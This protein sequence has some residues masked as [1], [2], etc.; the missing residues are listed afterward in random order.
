MNV[1][2]EIGAQA[3]VVSDAL[4]D[5]TRVVGNLRLAALLAAVGAPEARPD[6]NAVTPDHLLC[7]TSTDLAHLAVPAKQAAHGWDGLREDVADGFV[8][9]DDLVDARERLFE[10]NDNRGCR[11]NLRGKFMLLSRV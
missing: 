6:R 9:L 8:R 3:A 2:S 5:A 11:H 4:D 10:H 7:E 1:N